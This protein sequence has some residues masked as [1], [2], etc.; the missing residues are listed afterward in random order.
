VRGV[1]EIRYWA[2]YV[3]KE[4]NDIGFKPCYALP[5]AIHRPLVI[6]AKKVART[7]DRKKC[8]DLVSTISNIEDH[9][10][11]VVARYAQH[12]YYHKGLLLEE[13]EVAEILGWRKADASCPYHHILRMH[14][15]VQR[16]LDDFCSGDHTK[17]TEKEKKEEMQ[18][19]LANERCHVIAK[20]EKHLDWVRKADEIQ[21]RMVNVLDNA[22]KDQSLRFC[23]FDLE[24][25]I[26]LADE[27]IISNLTS[28]ATSGSHGG[29]STY[30]N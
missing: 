12:V 13:R 6:Y 10:W 11:G 18:E 23:N 17:E 21:N 25:L 9:L 20:L 28:D 16:F 2:A 1:G 7:A 24:A 26:K 14:K 5:I 22:I 15:E 30:T 4:G 19:R 8:L 29:S 3:T 27:E